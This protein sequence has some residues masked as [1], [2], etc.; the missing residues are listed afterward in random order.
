VSKAAP[1]R[2]KDDEAASSGAAPRRGREEPPTTD[3][4]RA[5]AFEQEP[6]GAALLTGDALAV[7]V[8]NAAFR[9]AMPRPDLDAVGRTV[10]EIWPSDVGL[11][12]RATVERVRSTGQP[13][14]FERFAQRGSDGALRRFTWHARRL[15]LR[16]GPAVL[17]SLWE[18]TE[19]ED[20]RAHA[21]RSRERAELLASVA[22]DLNAGVGLEAVLRTTLM[23]AAALLGAE[24]GSVWLVEGAD[25]L[26][27]VVELLPRGRAGQALP[28]SEVPVAALALRE[29]AARLLRAA[30]GSA[31][32]AEWMRRWGALA[33]LVV[34]ILE[35][36]RS[37]GV[38]YLNYQSDAFLPSA[39]DVAFAEAIAGGC[40]LALA[41]ARAF[42]AER[43]ARAR[44]ETAEQEALRAERVQ[45][46]L[47]AVVGHDL[48]TP[49]QAITLGVAVLE[50]RGALPEAD[51]RT[52]ARIAASAAKMERI[53]GDLLD[54][55]R[56]H[57]GGGVPVATAPVRLDEIVRA[58]A[59]ELAAAR[60]R[61]VPLE[62]AGDAL[63]QG[64]A[65]RLGQLASNLLGFALRETPPDGTVRAA[66]RGGA[67]QVELVVE[68][69]GL[70]LPPE[71][72]PALFE[73]F[74]RTSGDSLH[75]SLGLGLFIV[76]AIAAAHGGW[77]A[78]APGEDRT[79]FV[80]AL[81]RAPAAP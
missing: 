17:L 32:E 19:L 53:I 9:D 33:R 34:P 64:D 69:L 45:E 62:V 59:D 60:G 44:A 40:A 42:E 61:P 30:D 48:R 51:A 18:T 56:V 78:V 22:N 23:R 1:S 41:R 10:E 58:A 77:V 5:A 38:L 28:L 43:A 72:L 25:A 26:R 6:S 39:G 2:S 79:S 80:V 65:S 20:A 27:C 46:R 7:A 13:A 63:L 81:P 54:F 76:R 31:F 49:L 75:G 57:S 55:A 11:E 8:A 15:A 3:E 74:R 36:G 52:L 50:R 21:E 73:P 4:L 37:A 12:V 67:D 29:R 35:E 24:D 70:R 71:E 14:R 68:A 66:V 47:A 16:G